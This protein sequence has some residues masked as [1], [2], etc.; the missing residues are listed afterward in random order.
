MNTW[1][2][3]FLTLSAGCAAVALALYLWM[4]WCGMVPGPIW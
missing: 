3:G 1:W 4:W 2:P